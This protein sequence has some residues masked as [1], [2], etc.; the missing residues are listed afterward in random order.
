MA[1][2]LDERTDFYDST[3]MRAKVANAIVQ[4]AGNI[5]SESASG[6]EHHTLRATLA[7]MVLTEPAAWLDPFVRAV[8]Q[9]DSLSWPPGDT[10]IVNCVS[11]AWNGMAGAP[12]PA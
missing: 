12:G 6:T 8:A 3:R 2:T 1:L 4:I 5:Q 11:A 7:L 10:D 9:N